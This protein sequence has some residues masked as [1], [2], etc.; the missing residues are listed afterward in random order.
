MTFRRCIVKE[1]ILSSF[2][3]R[4][5]KRWRRYWEERW[6]WKRKE[7]K[8][9]SWGPR[10]SSRGLPHVVFETL[11][12]DH[13]HD[14]NATSLLF[15][16]ALFHSSRTW[17]DFREAGVDFGH[18]LQHPLVRDLAVS[19]QGLLNHQWNEVGS[20]R[21][22][23]EYQHLADTASC[24]E[25]GWSKYISFHRNYLK[26]LKLISSPFIHIWRQFH[27]AG[28]D[29]SSEKRVREC[30][31]LGSVLN[32]TSLCCPIFAPPR[33]CPSW[34]SSEWCVSSFPSRW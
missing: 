4:E 17:G 28:V 11:M 33:W 12:W 23:W 15:P 7:L 34:S 18:Y 2:L 24:T 20:P 3:N 10:F 25:V 31:D 6:V 8:A 16:C 1:W 32:D 19:L 21:G 14:L 5:Q 29:M 30:G 9:S 26:H 13:E 27:N 22:H